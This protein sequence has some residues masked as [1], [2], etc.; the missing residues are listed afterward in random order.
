VVTRVRDRRAPPELPG[1]T[2]PKGSRLAPEV[3][4]GFPRVSSD[5]KTLVF[6]LKKTYRFSDGRPLR[7]VNFVR[8]FERARYWRTVS[9]AGEFTRDVRSVRALGPYAL[10]IR[11]IRPTPDLLARLATPF[12][13]AVPA[14]L[15][16][17]PDGV[18]APLHT[19]GP[20]YFREW[21]RERT[22]VLARNPYY[23]G[24]RPRNV[25]RIR[26][27]F[28][29]GPETVKQ[30]IDRGE[31]D[32]GEIPRSAH[33]E[34]GRQYGVKKRSPGRYF[35]NPQPEIVFLA[36]NQDRPLFRRNVAL[37]RAVNFALDRDLLM[38]QYGSYG[39][40]AHDQILPPT[41][42]G[43]TDAKLYPRRPDLERARR[44][45]QGHLRI[46]RA[47]LWCL[48]YWPIPA[49]C[50][51]VQANLGAIGLHVHVKVFLTGGAIEPT[52][53]GDRF[54][55]LLWSRRTDYLDPYDMMRIV[56]GRTIR[57]TRNTNLS[58]FQG[59]ALRPKDR[60][61][62]R[63]SRPTALPRVRGAR[64]RTHAHRRAGCRDR[65]L[66]RPPVRLGANGLLPPPPRLRPRPAG[67]LPKALAPTTP[68]SFPCYPGS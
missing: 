14:R 37:R 28:R 10:R 46:G 17:D 48:P 52:T 12:F 5:G 36:L 39:G 65:H 31:M 20:Y 42:R 8:A 3:A 38:N 21:K 43:F 4:S 63:A 62:E 7:A 30:N 26:V 57:P 53:R 51:I 29:L 66:Q 55:L 22:L 9:R 47:E 6:R 27:D 23:R 24:P 34:L 11:T 64:R 41:I 35:V 50:Q 33:A 25:N 59:P 58:S 56:D 2:S 60:P 13:A 44:L 67:D 68:P 32:T 19:A 54:D 61:G 40:T 49:V 16:I 45:A 15:R 18:G 1:H